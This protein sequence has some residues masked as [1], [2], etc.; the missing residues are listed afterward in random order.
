MH[1]IM[2]QML[3]ISDQCLFPETYYDC[4]GICLQDDDFDGICNELEIVD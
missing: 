1:V 2:I 3:H 4:N